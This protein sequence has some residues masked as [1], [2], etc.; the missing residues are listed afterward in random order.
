[1]SNMKI[2][3]YCID[4]NTGQLEEN[5]CGTLVDYKI[6]SELEELAEHWCKSCYAL[7]RDCGEKLV[8]L[9]KGGE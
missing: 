3:R 7:R 6:I 4:L 1:M 5:D 2:R 8:E 9:L